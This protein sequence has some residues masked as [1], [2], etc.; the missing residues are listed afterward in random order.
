M[1][2]GAPFFIPNGGSERKFHDGT[3]STAIRQV[4]PIRTHGR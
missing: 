1:V 3:R 4:L 2:Y